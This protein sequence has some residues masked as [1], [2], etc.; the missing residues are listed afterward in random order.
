MAGSA[1]PTTVA[2]RATMPEPSTVVATTQRARGLDIR[3]PGSLPAAG[4][5]VSDMYASFPGGRRR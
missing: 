3:R 2:S 1:M 4:A 5:G